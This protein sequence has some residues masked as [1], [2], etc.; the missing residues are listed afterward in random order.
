MYLLT[1]GNPKTDKS[2]AFGYL[3]AILHLAPSYLS[4]R[5]VCP[6]ATPGCIA[7]CLN[8]AGRGGI[9]KAAEGRLTAPENGAHV[10][11]NAIQRARLARTLAF[12]EDRGAFVVKLEREIVAH[13][14]AAERAGLKPAVRLNGTSD[15]A[16]ERIAP[17]LFERFPEVQFYDYTKS[18]KRAMAHAEGRMPR[19]YH[20]TL[21]RS[22]SNER[23]CVLVHHAGGTV[24][25][26]CA[27][28]YF[29]GAIA[30]GGAVNGDLH[31]LRFLDPRGALV[32]LKAK[33]RAKR[34]A[35][36][37]VVRQ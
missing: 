19:N 29:E 20:L 26:V 31:D 10:P 24:A 6:H 28:D 36:G 37:F 32:A 8:T 15:L 11:D 12:F 18:A 25:A 23:D 4:G 34:D 27:P 30:H 33:G 14:R 17:H 22:E 13:V 16:W 21:S 5:N 2:A 9:A 1:T 7:A 3:T 35:S